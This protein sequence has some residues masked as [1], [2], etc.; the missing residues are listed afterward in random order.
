M[1]P[2]TGAVIAAVVGWASIILVVTLPKG[3]LDAQKVRTVGGVTIAVLGI[4]ILAGWP[5]WL[6]LAFLAGGIFGV[7]VSPGTAAAAA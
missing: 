3:R 5:G 2:L 7:W 1:D 4:A 6:A